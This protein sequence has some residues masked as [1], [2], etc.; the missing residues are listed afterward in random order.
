M[1]D[2]IRESVDR[3]VFALIEWSEKYVRDGD[4]KVT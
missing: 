3:H 4:P 1:V 2:F